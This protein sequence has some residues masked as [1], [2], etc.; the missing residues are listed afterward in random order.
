MNTLL[1]TA[2][3]TLESVCDASLTAPDG[4]A[5]NA[6]QDSTE[7]L[8][9]YTRQDRNRIVNLATA[10]PREPTPIKTQ[11][12]L[13]SNVTTEPEDATASRM[14]SELTAIDARMGTS[15]LTAS[16][17][18]IPVT[19]TLRDHSMEH[20]MF[21]RGNATVGP[22]SLDNDAISVS[23]ITMTFRW[24]VARHATATPVDQQT[25]SVTL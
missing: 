11:L 7:T 12:T 1:E 4:T 20:A 22:E 16:R 9:P 2:T 8:W 13:H 18:V 23:Q 15:I 14:L 17:A 3:G 6:K 24:T 5:K 10:T 21:S 25:F 19:A